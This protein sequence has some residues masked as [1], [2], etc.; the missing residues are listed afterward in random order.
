[1]AR[2]EVSSWNGL[3]APARAPPEVLA[4]LN[5][6]ANDALAQP[7]EQPQLRSL[8]VRVQGGTADVLRQVLAAETR[9]WAEVANAAKVEPQ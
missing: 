1:M 5:R 4:R 6:A 7:A 2:Y 9:H 3:A 8:G